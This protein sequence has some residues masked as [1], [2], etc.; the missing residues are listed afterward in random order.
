MT[1]AEFLNLLQTGDLVI[2]REGDRAPVRISAHALLR[3]N[4]DGKRGPEKPRKLLREVI[5]INKYRKKK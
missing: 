5:A 4:E 1:A 3:A 2:A